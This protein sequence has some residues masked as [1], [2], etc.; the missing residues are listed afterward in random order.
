MSAT[1]SW[2]AAR[3]ILGSPALRGR[4]E[5]FIDDD[6]CFL[7]PAIFDDRWS[8]GQRVLLEIAR[9]FVE[10]EHRVSLHEIA[11]TLDPRHLRLFIKALDVSRGLV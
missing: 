2:I 8:S 10:P 9:S 7:D 3:V 5:S 11:E 4:V 6:A 1:N